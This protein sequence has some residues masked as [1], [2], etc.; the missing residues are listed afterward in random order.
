MVTSR[1][2]VGVVLRTLVDK[3]GCHGNI[4]VAA[5]KYAELRAVEESP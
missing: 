3:E 4:C 1:G 5:A 2:R